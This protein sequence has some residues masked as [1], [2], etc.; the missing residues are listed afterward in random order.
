MGIPVIDHDKANH[1]VY[2]DLASLIG[3]VAGMGVSVM[4]VRNV[5]FMLVVGGVTAFVTAYVV[6]RLKEMRDKKANEAALSAGLP[7]PHSVEV[8]D[9]NATWGGSLP[10][11][12]SLLVAALF[13]HLLAR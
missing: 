7:A 4:L 5:V 9:I 3:A 2:G 8:A 12:L 13:T 6:G 1:A 11:S 10:T